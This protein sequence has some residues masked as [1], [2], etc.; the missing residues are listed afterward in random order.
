MTPIDE[1]VEDFIAIARMAG[2][3]GD[4]EWEDEAVMKQIRHHTRFKLDEGFIPDMEYGKWVKPLEKQN[5][6]A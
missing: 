2:H 5:E 1:E 6:A 3:I 4:K